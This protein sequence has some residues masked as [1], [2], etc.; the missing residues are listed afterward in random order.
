MVSEFQELFIANWRQQGGAPLR[1]ADYFPA[2]DNKGD[3]IVRVL[4]SVPEEF[5]TIYVTLISAIRNAETNVYITDAYFAPDPQMIEALEGAAR[6][7]VDVRVLLPGHTDRAA[8]RAGGARS[9]FR[10]AG[11]GGQDIPVAGEMLHAK[12][13]T[14]DGV[15]STV[16]SSNLDWWSIARNDEINTV[17]LSDRFGGQMNESFMRDLKNSEQIDVTGVGATICIRAN[18]RSHRTKPQ[19]DALE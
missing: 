11:G 19:A 1:F 17:V 5:S 8:D 2:P 10:I 6:R 12:T 7:G 9:F 4:G 13:A 18:R 16:G 14:I 15:W 3:E